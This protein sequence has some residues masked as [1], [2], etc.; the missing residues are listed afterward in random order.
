MASGLIV[1]GVICLLFFSGLTAYFTGQMDIEFTGSP[2]SS[3]VKTTTDNISFNQTTDICNYYLNNSIILEGN[4]ICDSNGL[5]SN[6]DGNNKLFFHKWSDFGTNGS[7]I[8]NYKIYNPEY[9][10]FSVI[11]AYAKSFVS[12]YSLRIKVFSD[13]TE[14]QRYVTVLGIPSPGSIYRICETNN[15]AREYFNFN[16]VLNLELHEIFA[17]ETFSGC[18]F[19]D[20]QF[21]EDLNVLT[22]DEKYV[23]GIEVYG[24]NL[25][26]QTM[27]SLFYIVSMSAL[28]R[29]DWLGFFLNM[30]SIMGWQLSPLILPY[31]LQALIIGIPE[32]MIII[33][34]V[35]L[36]YPWGD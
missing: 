3:Y 27:E 25:S 34:I 23:S 33:G 5:T 11:I 32:A 17:N 21:I 22:F 31:E 35:A 18:E 29:G 26:V 16:I 14:L 4:W 15:S 7:Y 28:Q 20:E 10:E 9:K 1:T 36:L 19:E 6:F 2:L 8:E 24:K 12:S 30:L 13:R